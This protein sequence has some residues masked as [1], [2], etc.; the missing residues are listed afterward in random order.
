MNA[1]VS[2][3]IFLRLTCCFEPPESADA[4]WTNFRKFRVQSYWEESPANSFRLI[5]EYTWIELYCHIVLLYFAQDNPGISAT[6][7]IY[8]CFCILQF[9]IPYCR[10]F[11]ITS[12]AI[13]TASVLPKNKPNIL[14]CHQVSEE[15][16]YF[17]V[18]SLRKDNIERPQNYL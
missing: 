17:Q 11:W 3:F 12:A 9:S 6:L 5:S 7:T 8:T 4:S 2:K 15:D 10:E 14:Q 1:S 13:I 18:I 16:Q